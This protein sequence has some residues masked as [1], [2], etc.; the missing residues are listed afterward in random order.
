MRR[1]I[2]IRLL[3]PLGLLALLAACGGLQ[4]IRQLDDLKQLAAQRQYAEIAQ[5]HVDCTLPRTRAA[6]SCG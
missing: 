1:W 6:I 3:V 5:Q 4:T 2:A